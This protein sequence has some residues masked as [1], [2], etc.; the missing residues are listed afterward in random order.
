LQIWHCV[1]VI[2]N[3]PPLNSAQFFEPFE[4]KVATIKFALELIALGHQVAEHR[5]HDAAEP[6]ERDATGES[7]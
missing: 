4:F 5:D 2:A 6:R 1:E 7:F 3:L